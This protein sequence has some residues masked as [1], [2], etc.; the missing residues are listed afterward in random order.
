MSIFGDAKY[1]EFGTSFSLPDNYPRVINASATAGSLTITVPAPSAKGGPYYY[2]YN[3]GANTF[4]VNSLSVAPRELLTAF[5]SESGWRATI[6]TGG[7]AEAPL[8]PDKLGYTV[9]GIRSN[10]GSILVSYN[11][12][13]DSWV[14]QINSTYSNFS[15]YDGAVASSGDSI[16]NSKPLNGGSGGNPGFKKTQRYSRASDTWALLTE[17]L[18][19]FKA[20][21]A[22]YY[23]GNYY[24]IG[25]TDIRAYDTATTVWDE[26][27]TSNSTQHAFGTSFLHDSDDR[28]Y[29]FGGTGYSATWAYTAPNNTLDYYDI[30]ADTWSTVTYSGTVAGKI[31][32]TGVMD[33]STF[34]VAGGIGITAQNTLDFN[35]PVDTHT[36]Y[37]T[38]TNTWTSETA[39]PDARYGKGAFAG[40]GDSKIYW[41]GGATGHG[42]TLT[43]VYDSTYRTFT[44]SAGTWAL[45]GNLAG[46]IAHIPASCTSAD[47]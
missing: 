18:T 40:V 45:V 2:I 16:Y 36:S 13:T 22:E 20:H 3:G 30:S 19:T 35:N 23:G 31:K 43:A 38:S 42:S 5:Y 7:V 21:A 29:M 34:Y 12:R 14:Q 44:P 24:P 15:G 1:L 9:G 10:H 46:T 26:G 41:I 4:S 6:R 39:L 32:S 33:G 25:Y 27:L 17:M 28:V 8:V 37:N 47:T 11:Y